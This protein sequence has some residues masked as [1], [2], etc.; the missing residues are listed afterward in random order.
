MNASG[1]ESMNPSR[2]GNSSA[3]KETDAYLWDRSG[4][5][6]PFV[7]RLESLLAP[8]S[9]RNSTEFPTAMEDR[10]N[11]RG[12]TLVRRAW[13]TGIA[14]ALLIAGT[15]AV[16]LSTS[17]RDGVVGWEVAAVEGRPLA[18]GTPLR[19][20]GQLPVGAWLETDAGSKAS[21]RV[22]S[23]GDVDLLPGSKVRITESSDTRHEIELAHG[24]LRA[25]ILAPPRLFFVQTRAALAT[26]MGC[27]YDLEMPESGPGLLSVTLGW[28]L[29]ESTW[30]G[31]PEAR[32]PAGISCVIDEQRGPGTPFRLGADCE[33]TVR[34][35][36]ARRWADVT[37]D[38]LAA[39][40]DVCGRG[41]AVTL[42]HVLRRVDADRRAGVLERLQAALGL[43]TDAGRAALLALESDA[44]EKLW[45]QVMWAR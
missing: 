2:V 19:A 12:L 3:P 42:W 1:N 21:V 18:N 7:E 35:L 22:A 30:E 36:D 27:R 26:D 44:M 16:Y 4:T 32:V 40:L 15:L 23:I 45:S 39:L 33:P 17:G 24:R 29:L 31:N 6:D 43:P 5:P 41:D 20:G 9:L 28:V 25:R 10:R 14:A 37:D 38:E 13:A 34:E 8:N 11:S